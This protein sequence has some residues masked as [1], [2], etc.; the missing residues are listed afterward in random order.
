M[1]E[2]KEKPSGVPE[3]ISY[4][5]LFPNPS[6]KPS[7]SPTGPPPTVD[8]A[9]PHC[10]PENLYTLLSC[11]LISISQ[12]KLT[13]TVS[14]VSQTLMSSFTCPEINGREKQ[15]MPWG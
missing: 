8:Y 11:F 7:I 13:N 3:F 1:K 5:F 4:F 12:Q 6:T 15:C 9:L 10:K 14:K 2:E